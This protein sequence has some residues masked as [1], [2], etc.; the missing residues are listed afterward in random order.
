[1]LTPDDNERPVKVIDVETKEVI[2]YYPSIKKCAQFLYGGTRSGNSIIKGLCS[3]KQKATFS[4]K[5]NKKITIR[6]NENTN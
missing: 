1:M 6:Y 2:C 4:E 3:G 5:L